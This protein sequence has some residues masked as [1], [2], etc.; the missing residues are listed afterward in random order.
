MFKLRLKIVR[1]LMGRVHFFIVANDLKQGCCLLGSNTPD[2]IIR[3]ATDAMMKVEV[4]KDIILSCALTY[5]SRCEEDKRSFIQ[6]LY[7][8]T[9]DKKSSNNN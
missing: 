7:G 6:H 2:V 3:S 8:L 4:I 5:L 9:E 1:W